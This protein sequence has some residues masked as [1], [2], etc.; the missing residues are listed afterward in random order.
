MEGHAPSPFCHVFLFLGLILHG[1]YSWLIKP[2]LDL[3]LRCRTFR[4][5]SWGANQR[6]GR[7]G[8]KPLMLDS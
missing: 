4:L 5:A 1:L 2:N 7:L 6:S 8:G 3:S